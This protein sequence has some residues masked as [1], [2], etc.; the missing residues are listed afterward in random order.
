MS[1]TVYNHPDGFTL[2]FNDHTLIATDD[3]GKTVSLPIGPLGLVELGLALLA[4]AAEQ[5]ESLKQEG[6]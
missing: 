1:S 4:L 6:R 3:D 2:A 5:D